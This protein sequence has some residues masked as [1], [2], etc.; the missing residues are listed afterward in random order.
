MPRLALEKHQRTA[1][2]EDAQGTPN[3]SHISPSILVYED[4]HVAR[5]AREHLERNVNAL[6]V[7]CSGSVAGSYL[8]LIDFVYHSSLGLRVIKKKK[9]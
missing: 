1:R 8:R 2:A 6:Q 5:L 4:Y 7:M 9:C 3:Q